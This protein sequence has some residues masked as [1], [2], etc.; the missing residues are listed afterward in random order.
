MTLR[1][2]FLALLELTE[3]TRLAQRI[4]YQERT[5]ERLVYAKAL[6]NQLDRMLADYKIRL[7]NT[8]P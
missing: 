1:E 2:A 6:E 3:Q 7:Q 8:L 5:K 4:Y